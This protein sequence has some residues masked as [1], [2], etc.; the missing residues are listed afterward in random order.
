MTLPAVYNDYDGS[1]NAAML[2]TFT[3]GSHDVVFQHLAAVMRIRF[4]N[5][6]AGYNQFVW[7][8]TGMNISGDFAIDYSGDHPQIATAAGSN[9]SVTFNFAAADAERAMTFYIPLPAGSYPAFT[10]ELKNTT[11]NESWAKL[12]TKGYTFARKELA[13]LP[14]ISTDVYD[15]DV[16][17]TTSVADGKVTYSVWSVEGLQEVNAL[18]Q[19][20]LDANI[21]LKKN[22][23]LDSETTWTPI[24]NSESPYTG[25]FDGYGYQIENLNIQGNDGSTTGLIGY[26]GNGGKV[27]DLTLIN[28]Q[29]HVEGLPYA[30]GTFA[31]VAASGS[32]I[33]NCYLR[34]QEPYVGA[35]NG[36]TGPQGT[37]IGGIVGYNY[38]TVDNCCID[39]EYRFV[40]LHQASTAGSASG[41]ALGGIA[42]E[43]GGIIRNC[44]I[45]GGSQ[46]LSEIKATY[47][48]GDI[49]GGIAG[50]NSGTITD[51][52]VTS[53]RIIGSSQYEFA[54]GEVELIRNCVSENIE[55]VA[56]EPAGGNS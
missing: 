29:I 26:L 4:S 42:G 20:D 38:G 50:I 11:T 53:I 34:G 44:T 21:T 45:D 2:A 37:R 28:S 48:Y 3:N 49:C 25:T 40:I 47:D 5:V 31:G 33:E 36:G 1:T 12:A 41:S 17:Y 30:L 23:I 39:P 13:L 27:K 7:T 14:E 35:V 54:N 51:C 19:A 9:N 16:D 6:P 32:R 10:A 56:S 18:V 8:A 22:F 55:M 15:Y 24:G 46:G 43:N 52:A